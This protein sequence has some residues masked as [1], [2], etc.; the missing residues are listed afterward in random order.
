MTECGQHKVLAATYR[1]G[2]E[3]VQLRIVYCLDPWLCPNWSQVRCRRSFS[4][5]LTGGQSAT[6]RFSASPLHE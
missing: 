2:G 3:E 5:I 4:R 6:R 1:N